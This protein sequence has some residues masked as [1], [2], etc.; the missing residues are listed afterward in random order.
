MIDDGSKQHLGAP[1]S[2]SIEDVCTNC[3]QPLSGSFCSQC[4]Q[5]NEPLRKPIWLFLKEAFIEFLG[6]DG[7]LWVSLKILIFRPGRLTTAYLKGQRVK[8]IRPLRMYLIASIL[9]FFLLS[10]IDPVRMID[11]GDDVVAADST[12][13]A[14]EYLETINSKKEHNENLIVEQIAFLDSLKTRYQADSLAF[15]SRQLEI[16]ADSAAQE[17]LVALEEQL[18]ELAEKVEEEELSGGI[19]K[20]VKK[21]SCFDE[22]FEQ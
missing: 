19:K 15:N 1:S 18:G 21:G 8:Y 10:M 6:V 11:F 22:I 16:D 14:A 17:E 20:E 13:T 7:R 5:R 9:F 4:G 2:E 3:S 12:I